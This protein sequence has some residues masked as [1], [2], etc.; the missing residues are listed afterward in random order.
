MIKQACS[1]AGAMACLLLVAGPS[2]AL[3]LAKPDANS[4]VTLAGHH[5]GH[6]GWGGH[7]GGGPGFAFRGSPGF[8]GGHHH[9][10]GPG[11]A[12][13]GSPGFAF[14]GIGPRGYHGP[15]GFPGHAYRHHGHRFY[16]YG[17]G[18]LPYYY[19]GGDGYYDDCAWLR[20]RAIATGSPYWWRRYEACIYYD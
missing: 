10:G 13:R 8:D 17:Y 2:S 9:G 20:R 7:H 15:H 6:G 11:F 5:G 16:P 18:F 12:L 19:Y 4:S 14:K 1:I 3:P